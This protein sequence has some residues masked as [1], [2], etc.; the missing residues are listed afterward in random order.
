VRE[1]TLKMHITVN[2]LIFPQKLRIPSCYQG[3]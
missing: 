1:I 2:S 3:A